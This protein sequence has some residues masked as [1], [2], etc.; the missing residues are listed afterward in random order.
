MDNEENQLGQ[1]A[2]RLWEARSGLKAE[3]IEGD[4]HGIK[5]GGGGTMKAPDTVAVSMSSGITIR[6][7]ESWNGL[8]QNQKMEVAIGGDTLTFTGVTLVHRAWQAIQCAQILEALG[9]DVP[10]V[11]GVFVQPRR[12]TLFDRLLRRKRP[13]E[14]LGCIRPRMIRR[15]EEVTNE[16]GV[17]EAN[18]MCGIGNDVTVYAHFHPARFEDQWEA[19]VFHPDAGTI[20]VPMYYNAINGV[21]EKVRGRALQRITLTHEV[22]KPVSIPSASRSSELLRIGHLAIATHPDLVDGHG[23]RIDALVRD[24]LPDLLAKHRKA[25]AG[26]VDEEKRGRIDEEFDQ[27]LDVV[28]SALDEAMTLD[29]STSYEDLLT[30]VRFLKMRH[31][32]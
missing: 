19:W 25:T 4:P 10:D 15:I 29:G 18:G 23:A 21:I 27:G 30:Q 22:R 12:P 3:L 6:M 8:H 7:T 32:A 20:E 1:I 2:T 28:A 5:L 9:G 11:P 24:H 13:F 16:S 17:I 26:A 14:T 31:P